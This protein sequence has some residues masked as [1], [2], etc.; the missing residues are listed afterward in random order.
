MK[1]LLILALVSVVAST[2]PDKSPLSI[3][4]QWQN[5]KTTHNKQYNDQEDEVK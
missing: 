5:F 4:E 2:A 3:E 1:G